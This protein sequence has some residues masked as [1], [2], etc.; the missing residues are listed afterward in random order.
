MPQPYGHSLQLQVA[1]E[2][3]NSLPLDGEEP[4]R[5]PYGVLTDAGET[6]I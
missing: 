4:P 3:D 5:S 2:E 1:D 6:L